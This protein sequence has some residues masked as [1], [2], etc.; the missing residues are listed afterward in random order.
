VPSFTVKAWRAVRP[1]SAKDTGVAG[2][3][4]EVDKAFKKAINAMSQDE[5]DKAKAALKSL[6]EALD[7]GK[8]AID[9]DKKDKDRTAALKL[10]E[11]WKEEIKALLS[12]LAMSAA[13][14]IKVAAVQKAY[15]ER[16]DKVRSDV[17]AHHNAARDHVQ[18]GTRPSDQD[19]QRYLVSVRDGGKI[20]SKQ[21]IA[22]ILPEAKMVKV[23][24]IQMPNDVK[25]IK[26]KIEQLMALC[27]DFAKAGKKDAKNRAAALDDTVAADK[28]VKAVMDAYAAVEKEMKVLIAETKR[29]AS[30]AQAV[31]ERIKDAIANGS[32]DSR[33][34][35][36]LVKAAKQ[37]AVDLKKCDDD[38]RV[39]GDRWRAKGS[40]IADLVAAARKVDG[41]DEKTHGK[42]MV[43]RMQANQM[44]IRQVSIPHGEGVRQIER[45][46]RLLS[47]SNDHRGFASGF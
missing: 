2:A 4:G 34:F 19:L 3:I 14:T 12:D 5:I 16:Y 46:K 8:K 28:A 35:T 25:I 15:D 29:Q 27:V 33:T 17:V 1:E 18:K 11:S 24:D 45:A 38:L 37:I 10:I 44:L 47:D 13:Y 31:A 6:S 30:L 36:P 41:F 40:P 22:D 9:E 32:P 39:I 20:C 7:K 43:D 42:L 21:S 26:A 23:E